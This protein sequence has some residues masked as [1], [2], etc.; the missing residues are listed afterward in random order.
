MN[1][2]NYHINLI[3]NWNLLDNETKNSYFLLTSN[4]KS[5]LSIMNS[6]QDIIKLENQGDFSHTWLNSSVDRI[7]L[8]ILNFAEI[9]MSFD[10]N[11]SESEFEN[12]NELKKLISLSKRPYK[13][14]NYKEYL[15]SK[16]DEIG[17][18]DEKNNLVISDPNEIR[19]LILKKS[20]KNIKHRQVIYT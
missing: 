6:I 1:S 12:L 8:I 15:I 4:K 18:E 7:E 11:I 10:E 19:S 17:F 5:S 13:Q 3:N 2:S 16:Y 14:I 9:M 20:R